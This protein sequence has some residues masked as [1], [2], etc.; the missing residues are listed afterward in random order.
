MDLNDLSKLVVPCKMAL[1]NKIAYLSML[2]SIASKRYFYGYCK[3]HHF[4][5]V[6]CNSDSGNARDSGLDF[7][8]IVFSF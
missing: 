1:N 5:W 4:R 3:G 7:I 2:I 6:N 8:L